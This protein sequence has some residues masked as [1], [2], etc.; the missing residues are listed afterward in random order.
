MGTALD[1][2]NRFYTATNT[3]D[4]SQL[5][6]LVSDDVAFEGPLMQARGATEYLAMN[7]Q[8][9]GFHQDTTMLHQF[10]DGDQVC[11]MYTLGMGTPSGTDG[12]MSRSI[13]S[14]M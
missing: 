11:S 5:A 8:L 1:V 2:V 14:T 6:D 4:A 12:T 7:A 13:Q 10:E 3:R 9:L